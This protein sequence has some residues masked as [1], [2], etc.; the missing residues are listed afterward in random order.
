M[1]SW[2]IWIT[3]YALGQ[4]DYITSS[5]QNRGIMKY[6]LGRCSGSTLNYEARNATIKFTQS[7]TGKVETFSLNQKDTVIIT[8]E[9]NVYYQWGR[10]DPM[11][12]SSGVL[13]SGRGDISEV[14][15]CYGSNMFMTED[16]GVGV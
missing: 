5:E 10:N 15:Q 2:D 7:S 12:P 3:N 6:S 11:L 8:K 9:S 14:T 1:G 13:K 4:D 16:A